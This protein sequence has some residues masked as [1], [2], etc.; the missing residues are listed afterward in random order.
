MSKVEH[1]LIEKARQSQADVSKEN[2]TTIMSNLVD[3]SRQKTPKKVKEAT[4]QSVHFSSIDL[5]SQ[6]DAA[7]KQIEHPFSPTDVPQL[8]VTRKKIHNVNRLKTQ[9]AKERTKLEVIMPNNNQILDS[10]PKGISAVRSDISNQ[11]ID[12]C[13]KYQ[14][15]TNQGS[16][17]LRQNM[18]IHLG[19]LKQQ[20]RN[21]ENQLNLRPSLPGRD[22]LTK[23]FEIQPR[24]VKNSIDVSNI[25]EDSI[26]SQVGHDLSKNS[27]SNLAVNTNTN[28]KES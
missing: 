27:S 6:H 7:A 4:T 28:A 19:S 25:A 9:A 17:H 21:Q 14:K 18:R 23:H 15:E 2:T 11:L 12:E 10:I 26:L 8:S 24:S 13:S 3:S 22:D 16:R 20:Y 1:I 5:S